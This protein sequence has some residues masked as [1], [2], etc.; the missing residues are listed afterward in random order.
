MKPS[1][2]LFLFPVFVVVLFGVLI[3]V[4]YYH[5][6]CFAL[7]AF[8]LGQLADQ[9]CP[10]PRLPFP[11]PAPVPPQIFFTYVSTNTMTNDTANTHLA[12]LMNNSETL[13]S[14]ARDPSFPQPSCFYGADHTSGLHLDFLGGMHPGSAGFAQ[15]Q[16]PPDGPLPAPPNPCQTTSPP[17]NPIL[18]PSSIIS[19]YADQ[20]SALNTATNLGCA[21]VSFVA[22]NG[23]P[24]EVAA[25]SS[26][27]LG[28]CGLQSQL[29]ACGYFQFTVTRYDTNAD[30]SNN[31][32]GYVAANFG[33]FLRDG[34]V[35]TGPGTF[36]NVVVIYGGSLVVSEVGP[37]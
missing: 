33:F 13:D 18:T 23:A 20:V 3:V 26:N 24:V 4:S 29:N 32:S 8:G 37:S 30:G 12:N 34:C 35:P 25:Y 15:I 21:D 1:P 27:D 17:S 31:T 6:E 10:P 5:L 11:I 14:V 22:P 2:K 7:R 28:K 19:L 36:S 9:L 16:T